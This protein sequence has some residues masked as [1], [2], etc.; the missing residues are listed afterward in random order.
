MKKG[1]RKRSGRASARPRPQG[2][3]Q[4]TPASALE[5][6]PRV[7][8]QTE[9]KLRRRIGWKKAAVLRE[10]LGDRRFV[11][12]GG[13]FVK[14]TG[15][16]L[17]KR[18]ARAEAKRA[19]I[20]R[21]ENLS[22]RER[23]RLVLQEDILR[24]AHTERATVQRREGRSGRA[25][26]YN[27][28]I[29]GQISRRVHGKRKANALARRMDRRANL[30]DLRL[31]YDFTASEAQAFVTAIRKSEIKARKRL[32]KHVA[33]LPVRE[34]AK[35]RRALQLGRL[36]GRAITWQIDFLIRLLNSP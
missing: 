21:R 27:V 31:K 11:L 15:E 24:R 1:G 30:R 8:R 36:K 13:Q 5:I 33:A 25:G 20:L 6:N 19:A 26:W 28:F 29:A 9:T 10:V 34:R 16:R 12:I 23:G 18:M 22:P 7:L 35:A 17:E 4:R 2:K 3:R 14:R 32:L